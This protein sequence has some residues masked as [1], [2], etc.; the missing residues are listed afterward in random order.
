[1]RPPLWRTAV[2]VVTA[3]TLVTAAGCGEPAEDSGPSAR[4]SGNGASEQATSPGG[5]IGPSGKS[6]V[7]IVTATVTK[8]KVR[9]DESRVKVDRGTAVHITVTSDAADEFHLH[10]Y[11]R[12]VELAPG[13]PGTLDLV[14]DRPGVFEAE[15]HHSGAR[16]FELQVN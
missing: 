12:T 5:G 8:G 4:P 10:G 14:A 11:D 7:A 6:A 9:I 15:L 3:G 16:V 2:A 1:M 13:R